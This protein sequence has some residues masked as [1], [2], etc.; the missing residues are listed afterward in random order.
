MIDPVEEGKIN[1]PTKTSDAQYNYIYNGWEED[2]SNIVSPLVVNAVFTNELRDYPVYFYNGNIRLQESRVYYG[3]RASYN[4]DE[5]AIKKYIGGEPS[6]Y[7][8][9]A[10]WS[11]SISEPITGYTEFHAQFVFDGYIDDTWEN[12]I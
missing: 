1:I 10:Q 7:Y 11:P 2:F 3:A 6:D 5:S 12:I 8:E 4:G 9:F